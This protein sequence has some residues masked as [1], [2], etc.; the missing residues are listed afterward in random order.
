MG[1]GILEAGGQFVPYL[2]LYPR[3]KGIIVFVEKSLHR[4]RIVR[5]QFPQCPGESF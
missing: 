3:S 1:T 2:T 4:M 5:Y